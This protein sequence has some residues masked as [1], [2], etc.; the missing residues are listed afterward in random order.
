MRDIERTLF[1]NLLKRTSIQTHLKS[2][3]K[4]A[5]MSL[6][7]HALCKKKTLRG[8]HSPFMNKKLSKAILTRTKLRN[9]FRKNQTDENQ[10]TLYA[11]AKLLVIGLLLLSFN[12][13]K[14]EFYKN[15]NDKDVIYLSLDCLS[16]Q[17]NYKLWFWQY[18]FKVD[19]Q[20]FN[21][22]QDGSFCGSS[23]KRGGGQNEGKNLSHLSYNNE[24]L[25]VIAWRKKIHKINKS[26]DILLEFC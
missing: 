6:H 18:L 26:R 4:F 17:L 5:S 14:I 19:V 21:P 22:I 23:R 15:I 25:A 24:T 8:N 20:L 2:L 9:K 11:A 12:N 7:Q 16:Y 1:W 13:F 10:K 3:Q